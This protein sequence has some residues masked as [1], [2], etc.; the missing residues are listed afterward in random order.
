LLVNLEKSEIETIKRNCK[1]TLKIEG[2]EP[3]RQGQNITNLFLNGKIDSKTAVEQI[4][5]YWGCR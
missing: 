5:K 1:A 2:L 3:S 4:K